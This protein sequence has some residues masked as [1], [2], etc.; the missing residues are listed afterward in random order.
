MSPAL[1]SNVCKAAI[2][3]LAFALAPRAGF[4]FEE[5]PETELFLEATIPF[6]PSDRFLSAHDAFL[7]FGF[8]SLWM[9]NH[10]DLMGIDPAT[11]QVTA[12]INLPGIKGPIR[13][14]ETGGDAIWIADT[15][16]GTIYKVD[17]ASERVVLKF[18]AKMLTRDSRIG[19]GAGSL[20]VVTGFDDRTLTRFN[21][22]TGTVEA[23]IPLPSQS[24]GGAQYAF[25]SVWVVSTLAN[26]LYRI[27]PATN[28]LVATTPLKP[29]PSYLLSA[30]GSIWVNSRMGWLQRIDPD[31][32][33]VIASIKTGYMGVDQL[34]AG[35]GYVWLGTNFAAVVQI[36]PATNT[37][38][39]A[40]TGNQLHSSPD[41]LYAAGSLW[42]FQEQRAILR[43]KPP[44]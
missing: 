40:Y 30:E 11:G 5:R 10:P 7:F 9:V 6:D 13:Y 22:T 32:N 12:R 20:W 17:P 34:A 1:R 3:G 41:I 33:E 24:F 25:G 35:G 39:R 8:G 42:T 19:F 23:D 15:G 16:T 44:N 36:D 4:A 2:L 38:V 29:Q 18:A 37:V 28:A 43:I 26:E 31:T 21:A 14:P 27:D